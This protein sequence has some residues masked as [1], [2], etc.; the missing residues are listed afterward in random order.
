MIGMSFFHSVIVSL[1]GSLSQGAW[2]QP[3]SRSLP[4]AAD[5]HDKSEL[6]WKVKAICHSSLSGFPTPDWSSIDDI[7][8][9]S[10]CPHTLPPNIVVWS[11]GDEIFLTFVSLKLSLFCLHL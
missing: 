1:S 2:V 9:S 3:H 6:A 4:R 11:S 5:K 8:L 7:H 10:L